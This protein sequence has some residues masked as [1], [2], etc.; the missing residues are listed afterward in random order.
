MIAS[1]CTIVLNLI[2]IRLFVLKGISIYFAL[3]LLLWLNLLIFSLRNAGKRSMLLAFLISFF[4]FLI[5]RDFLQ[6]L[7]SYKPESLPDDANLHLHICII[8]SLVS[9]AFGYFLCLF[10]KKY[11]ARVLQEPGEI[12]HSR[13]SIE[14]NVKRI[15]KY[16]FVISWV[17]A[18]ISKLL[19]AKYVLSHSYY[20]YYTDY[21][22]Y[23]SGNT[24]YYIVSKLEGIMPVALCI[25]CATLPSKKECSLPFILYGVY[26]VISLATGQRSVFILGI[27][28]LMVYFLYRNYL[29][30]GEG[31]I[32]RKMIIAAVIALPVLAV[33]MTLLSRIR[34][35]GST[36]TLS[37][38]NAILDFIYGQGVT[39]NV[40]KRAYMYKD[41]I[42]DQ[43]Y[44]LEFLHSGIFARILGIKVY[45]GNTVEHALYGG[46]FT[47]SL[48]YVVLGSSYLAG[49]G[50]GSSYV[51]ELYH[52]F[53]YWG[54][55]IGNIIY[56]F[57]IAHINRP[58]T[59]RNVFLMSARFF[60][61]TQILWAPRASLTGFISNLF[62]PI[63][64]LTFI[65]V[66]GLA[67]L[68]KGKTEG[69]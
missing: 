25:F 61:I 35:G 32:S 30:P 52:S 65:F 29:T 46:S 23:P 37:I 50:T 14:P 45:H 11:R 10:I 4:T 40:I 64:I 53:G 17:F 56:G 8:I 57:I 6:L 12:Y 34:V 26:I 42:P 33:M 1:I 66:F 38:K 49:R 13:V 36:Q 54:V 31:W 9:L 41:R 63:T 3:V 19:V 16:L 58:V 22:V 48:G 20:E 51:A 55:A 28:F 67:N 7:F 44:P 59:K 21:S 43:V 24:L 5:G 2:L 18:I 68:V 62:A 60:I 47:H 27:L 15:S 69:V 39:G